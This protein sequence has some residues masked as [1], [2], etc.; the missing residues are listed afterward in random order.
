M[1][2]CLGLCHVTSALHSRLHNAIKTHQAVLKQL[3]EHIRLCGKSYF[4]P[5]T[6]MQ[7]HVHTFCISNAVKLHLLLLLAPKGRVSYFRP[8]HCSFHGM[9]WQ[10]FLYYHFCAFV[11][12]QCL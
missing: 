7:Q 9:P 11:N 1:S 12:N 8:E 5:R 3:Y 2:E 10:I 4:V 6:V